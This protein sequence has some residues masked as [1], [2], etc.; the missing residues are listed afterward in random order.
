MMIRVSS[1][2]ATLRF[3]R[4]FG[5]SQFAMFNR[6][7]WTFLKILNV[8]LAIPALISTHKRK[9]N[10]SAIGLF[11]FPCCLQP[12]T[13]GLYRPPYETAYFQVAL[14][15]AF[16]PAR[17]KT[18]FPL[19][20]FCGAIA[21]CSLEYC[22]TFS[23]LQVEPMSGADMQT[24]IMLFL[25]IAIIIHHMIACFRKGRS[26]QTLRLSLLGQH[27]IQLAHDLKG[28]LSGPLLQV[29]AVHN[30]TDEIS[31]TEMKKLISFVE[32]D[33]INASQVLSQMSKMSHATSR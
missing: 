20:F 15:C 7:L 14:A 12:F 23:E 25:V 26:L 31:H 17:N 33:L 21:M 10:D 24:T 8:R 11:F 1:A 32:D 30:R 4:T 19:I 3:Q 13:S 28:L 6:P 9:A 16:I 18:L 22:R 29:T 27:S 2:P 5:L